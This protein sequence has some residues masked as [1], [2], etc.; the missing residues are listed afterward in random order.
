[1]SK[2]V[3]FLVLS[4]AVAACGDL[5]T[6][7][8]VSS[9]VK[10]SPEEQSLQA[11]SSAAATALAEP[12]V[13][14]DVRDAMRA[15]LLVEHRVAFRGYLESPGGARMLASM[16]HAMD[17]EPAAVLSALA[18]LP[19]LDFYVPS[20]E[21]RRTWQASDNLIV[22]G[23][24]RLLGDGRLVGFTPAGTVVP[25]AF[26]KRRPG[27]VVFHVTPAGERFRRV[28]PQSPL[29]GSVI[30]DADDGT[31]GGRFTWTPAGGESV[32]IE[33]ADMAG[34]SRT[35]TARFTMICD[36]MA[37]SCE[38]DGSGGSDP[39]PADTTRLDYFYIHYQEGYGCGGADPSFIAKHYTAAGMLTGEGRLDYSGLSRHDDIYP[40]EPLIF[41][42]IRQGTSE[43][44]N[45]KIVDRDSW[46]CGGDDDK[47]NRDYVVSENGI[48]ATIFRGSDPTMNA[49]LGWTPKY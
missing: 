15:S 4:L 27:V 42:R 24:L 9:R 36:P 31:Y 29:P 5:G 19:D 2:L 41:R 10:L 22:A 28:N 21:D 49:Q 30:E 3:R 45:L 37:K 43:R 23:A 6:T 11:L 33:L 46:F 8:S 25:V 18:R 34:V 16:A 40:R 20:R 44:I 32:A 35:G 12:Q 7:S 14:A 13:R 38:E 48:I 26:E 1:M 47:G 39:A 17:T